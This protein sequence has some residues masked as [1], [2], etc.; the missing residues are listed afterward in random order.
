MIPWPAFEKSRIFIFF[1]RESFNGIYYLV[2]YLF[3]VHGIHR[4]INET[5]ILQYET[6]FG[7]NL[8]KW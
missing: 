6:M 5:D 2:Y 7:S 4:P 1:V 8:E 3:L